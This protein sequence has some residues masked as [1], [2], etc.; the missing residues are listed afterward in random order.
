[1]LKDG[2]TFGYMTSDPLFVC[3][4]TFHLLARLEFLRNAT[5]TDAI[6]MVLP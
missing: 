5:P 6:A 1:L 2:S 3:G 4:S